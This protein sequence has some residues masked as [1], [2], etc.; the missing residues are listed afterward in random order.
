MS[1]PTSAQL[2]TLALARH[3]DHQAVYSEGF[4]HDSRRGYPTTKRCP[5]AASGDRAG[6]APSNR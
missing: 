6:Q 3:P 1:P 2:L 5:V 4:E